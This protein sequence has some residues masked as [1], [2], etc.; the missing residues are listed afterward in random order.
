MNL[1]CYYDCIY[2]IEHD[3]FNKSNL[4]YCILCGVYVVLSW[5]IRIIE[6]I[7]RSDREEPSS[8]CLAS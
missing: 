2:V 5:K 6:S 4:S 1:F 3:Y 8:T 7:N